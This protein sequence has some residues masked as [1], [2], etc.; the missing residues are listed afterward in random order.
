MTIPFR[1]AGPFRAGYRPGEPV[2]L[3]DLTVL[4]DPNRPPLLTADMLPNNRRML[5]RLHQYD[6]NYAGQNFPAAFGSGLLGAVQSIG[7]VPA[8]LAR[9]AVTPGASLLEAL[10][11]G[12]PLTQRAFQSADAITGNDPNAP[13][14][15]VASTLGTLADPGILE[16]AV[17]G[18]KRG[19]P[20]VAS[21][22]LDI[23]H[24]EV[25][26][27]PRKRGKAEAIRQ[28]FDAAEAANPQTAFPK[29]PSQG[30]PS[31]PITTPP[32]QMSPVERELNSAIAGL[33]Q[34]EQLKSQGM[35]L[36]PEA[37]AALNQ[38]Y[39]E[40]LAAWNGTQGP[41]KTALTLSHFSP[42]K[43]LTTIDPAKAGTGSV[44]SGAER[45]TG[46]KGAHYFIEGDGRRYE[47]AFDPKYS[48]SLTRYD[49]KGDFAL[50]DTATDP[51]G[52]AAKY[53]GKNR[54]RFEREL[55]SRGYDGFTNTD[56]S[57]Q[58]KQTAVL[59]K[60]QTPVGARGPNPDIQSVVDRLGL[61]SSALPE[62]AAV[63]PARGKEMAGIY[64]KLVNE[65]NN[66]E[67]RSA[68]RAFVDETKAQF[69]ALK[70]AGYRFEFVTQDP[71]K[72]SAE[73]MADLRN[74]KRLKV[75]KTPEGGH[76]LMTPEEN[77]IFRAVH[78][79]I[80]HGA[81]GYQFG[82]IG[83]EN[84]FRKHL[85]MYSPEAQRA[86]A[87][88]TRG[89]N[90]W[91]NFGPNSHLKMIERPFAEQKAALWPTEYL[92]D[93]G[94]M[95][96]ERVTGAAVRLD[97]TG[98][99]FAGAHHP[100][101]W[102]AAGKAYGLTG[103]QMYH[104]HPGEHGFMTSTGRFLDENQALDFAKKNK[105]VPEGFNTDEGRLH[106]SD[107]VP[108]ANPV[109]SQLEK[110][111]GSDEALGVTRESEDD[112]HLLPNGDEY[113]VCTN[114]AAHVVEREGGKI[115]GW[116]E[117]TNKSAGLN[118]MMAGDG[119]DFAI[120]HNGRYLVDPWAKAFAGYTDQTVFDLHD[121]A[122]AAKVKE[123]YGD[124]KEW[125]QRN[126]GHYSEWEPF[127]AKDP[128]RPVPAP[129]TMHEG[130]KGYDFKEVL[131]K[132]KAKPQPEGRFLT[133]PDGSIHG[134]IPLPADMG[135]GTLKGVIP[136]KEG[137]LPNGLA[138]D[139]F[140]KNTFFKGVAGKKE[141]DITR[142]PMTRYGYETHNA[143]HDVEVDPAGN[144]TYRTNGKIVDPSRFHLAAE[145][146]YGLPPSGPV[147][148]EMRHNAPIQ[149]QIKRGPLS[150]TVEGGW[151]PPAVHTG[152]P[153]FDLSRLHELPNITAQSP[154]PQPPGPARENT[155]DYLAPV[156]RR[157]T[158][159]GYRQRA[160]EGLQAGGAAWYNSEP[161]YQRFVSELGPVEGKKR[162]D[163][164]QELMGATSPR[165]RVPINIRL[166]SNLFHKLMTGSEGP[167]FSLGNKA[168]E[169]GYGTLAMDTHLKKTRTVLETGAADPINDPKTARYAGA[170]KGNYSGVPL[171]V[172]MAKNMKLVSSTGKKL[173][174]PPSNAYGLLE[175]LFVKEAARAGV[176]PA[177]YQAGAWIG[178][179]GK[180]SHIA[181]V[182][183]FLKVFDDRIA[184]T[185]K[186]MGQS[187]EKTLRDF[188]N[189]S[190]PLWALGGLYAGG[191]GKESQ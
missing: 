108:S 148:E 143:I 106:T 17:A 31:N 21:S 146:R 7:T 83:E 107:M 20:K 112:P 182:D 127:N 90:S 47:A 156:L 136:P 48:P 18:L 44:V 39:Q 88:E 172:H 177:Q 145:E 67:V 190:I 162:F 161:L 96:P 52:L 174:A 2:V 24:D 53:A 12:G 184:A 42:I 23:L 163:L 80:G 75:F 19:A 101:A 6:L 11:G 158:S 76:P 58:F 87:T 37:Q 140:F 114:C 79:A 33:A 98:E 70:D 123:L 122:D 109:K 28:A 32:E 40:A 113:G 116:E 26:S 3:P 82:P 137:V 60:P 84:A 153:L 130:D 73:V 63:D 191:A 27:V 15:G 45:A 54:K 176:A 62:V 186:R 41:P 154:F 120:T 178:N 125:K 46:A 155:L 187:K 61:K 134:E 68:Y 185:A 142:L 147:P 126:I 138:A 157:I 179:A 165:A 175:N 180:S 72:N 74:N 149:T 133:A 183:P 22:F 164:F 35:Q 50:Y 10:L 135:G 151:S 55:L 9:A 118:R 91:V 168:A 105:L 150:T 167:L 139:R 13:M 59:L 92:T 5:D 89:Q 93:Y 1:P 102:E 16:G 51:D 111:Y 69:Q 121:P 103:E 131:K 171:D 65:P 117:G 8:D 25:G 43:G 81:G 49:V 77:D 152:G 119:H 129:G 30:V 38:R 34:A 56:D 170:L 141:G 64:D 100:D 173:D 166:A 124:P 94:Q 85:A 97:K 4:P 29:A 78:D 189:G 159:P 36:H 181:N 115:V 188:I 110:K 160:L 71:Y 57:K 128:G 104:Q 86:M 14:A 99:T 132:Q 144:R 66:P 95:P 169:P